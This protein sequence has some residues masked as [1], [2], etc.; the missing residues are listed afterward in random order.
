M[1]FGGGAG[2]SIWIVADTMVGDGT[3]SAAGGDEETQPVSNPESS[4][5]R[6]DASSDDDAR[7]VP[8][9]SKQQGEAEKNGD[10]TSRDDNNEDADA[11]DLVFSA[12]D[13]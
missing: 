11:V 3:I 8:E 10:V 1:D 12:A 13:A 4:T 6:N 9:K 5:P 7:T 2:G